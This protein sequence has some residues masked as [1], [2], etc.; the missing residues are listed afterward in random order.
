MIEAAE[1]VLRDGRTHWRREEARRVA[2]LVD[3]EAYFAAFRAA[4]LRARHV[5]RIVGWDIHSRMRLVPGTPE[6]GFPAELGPFLNALLH[7]RPQLHIDIL[8]WDFAAIYSIEREP[9]PLLNREWR[10]HRRLRL[11][12]AAD[13]PIGAS[14]HQ[15]LVLIDDAVAFVGGI[16]LTMRRWDSSEHRPHDRRRVDP[17]GEPYQAFHDLQILVDGAAAR[18][19]GELARERWRR[20]IGKPL[21]P[22]PAGLDPWPAGLTPD[23]AEVR[24][25]IARTEPAHEGR[26]AV[27]EVRRLWLA[28][29]AA[30]Q[31]SIYIENQYFT[32][33]AIADA[34]ERRLAS[35]QS[36]EIVVVL[37]RRC[38]GWLEQTALADCQAR[39][40]RRLRAADRHGKLRLL[41]PALSTA[42]EDED[43]WVRVHGK[44]LVV[45]DRLVRVGS[46]NL[47]N[48][49]MGVDTECD[50][51]I[52]AESGAVAAGIAGYRDRLLG[53]H[54][55]AR[56]ETVAEAVCAHGLI[57]AIEH[58][59]QGERRLLPLEPGPLQAGLA[60]DDD[61]AADANV[62]DPEQ[63][64]R[65]DRFLDDFLPEAPPRPLLWRRITGSVAM[66]L[67]FAAMVAVWRYTPLAQFLT[68]PN[69]VA[70]V[71]MLSDR[72]WLP[73]YVLAAFLFSGFLMVPVTLLIAA[74]GV[75]FGPVMGF[76]YA[77][78]GAFSSAA[79][80]FLIGRTIGRE[81]VRR[82]AGPHLNRISRRLARSGIVA[83]TMMRLLPI[84][85]FTLVNIIAGAMH[86]RFR[87]FFA[88]TV[89]G[90][91]PG[92]VLMTSLGVS[93]ERVLRHGDV[94]SLLVFFAVILVLAAL[95]Y[96][97]QRWLGVD[98]DRR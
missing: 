6:D 13:H 77:A 36:P 73:V 81:P 82:L 78:L 42:P 34:I 65:P 47:S 84:A 58:L 22:V 74:T 49:S 26:A 28:A 95:G 24:V 80:S 14:H 19:I 2:F 57:G 75:A 83:V 96:A 41:Y 33:S 45:D 91:T 93:A 68:L 61:E 98:E 52:E 67:L 90:M 59:S 7:R 17:S 46:S 44:A 86:L 97:L 32:A 72:P 85:P 3:G 18:A 9:L 15:K 37:P 89:L 70:E 31:R 27:D 88:G 16:D 48:R 54:L 87:D 94:V 20:A 69:L 12:F 55:G 53:E 71:Q 30:A 39:L 63:P 4:C 60:P 8:I 66:A 79:L 11:R 43:G 64:I 1:T 5:I 35:P 38:H 40:I 50:L 25:A 56:P 76:A 62:F 10:A 21:P 23:L 29:I 92:I 51:A